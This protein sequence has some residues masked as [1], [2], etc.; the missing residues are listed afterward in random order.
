MNDATTF[1]G[2]REFLG[3][4][5]GWM[6]EDDLDLYRA[7]MIN[8]RAHLQY[9]IKDA[10]L[11]VAHCFALEDSAES[12][13]RAAELTALRNE[14]VRL[15]ILVDRRL[16]GD[17]TGPATRQEDDSLDEM[18]ERAWDVFDVDQDRMGVYDLFLHRAASINALAALRAAIYS[19][20]AARRRC[21][22]RWQREKLDR[23]I[24]F[25][26]RIEDTLDENIY[27]L[28]ALLIQKINEDNPGQG[29]DNAGEL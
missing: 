3:V 26:G 1:H 8:I 18:A 12:R 7:Q 5:T 11:A 20:E 6:S 27:E 13:A 9:L 28:S 17:D 19:T 2:I 10:R 15:N 14:A 4:D 23:R 25:A 29:L 22:D 21:D 16:N 24:T